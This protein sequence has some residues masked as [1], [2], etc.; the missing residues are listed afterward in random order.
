MP[1]ARALKSRDRVSSVVAT[2]RDGTRVLLES[3]G[4]LHQ[5]TSVW[6]R[7]LPSRLQSVVLVPSAIALLHKVL[8]SRP[9]DHTS[10]QTLNNRHYS[11]RSIDPRARTHARLPNM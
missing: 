8:I 10:V 9:C 6:C 2:H 1:R 4:G 7:Q 11:A 5:H 3:L